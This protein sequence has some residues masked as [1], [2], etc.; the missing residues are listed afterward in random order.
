MVVMVLGICGRDSSG[1]KD[2]KSS[3]FLGRILSFKQRTDFPYV[4]LRV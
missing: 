3:P 1:Y 4:A 2:Y